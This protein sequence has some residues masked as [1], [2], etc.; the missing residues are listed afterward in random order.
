MKYKTVIYDIT[1]F[2]GSVNVELQPQGPTTPQT[3]RT[4]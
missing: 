4:V 1:T 2:Y 3:D